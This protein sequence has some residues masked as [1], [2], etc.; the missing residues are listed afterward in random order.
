MSGSA[1][2]RSP[3]DFRGEQNMITWQSRMRLDYRRNKRTAGKE[4]MFEFVVVMISG[5]KLLHKN[6]K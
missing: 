2:S 3:S 6:C 1:Y 5:V 4:N